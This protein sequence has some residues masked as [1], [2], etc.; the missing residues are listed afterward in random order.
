VDIVNKS[1]NQLQEWLKAS[2]G[3]ILVLQKAMQGIEKRHIPA[4]EP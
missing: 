4:V 3:A 1:W 2:E